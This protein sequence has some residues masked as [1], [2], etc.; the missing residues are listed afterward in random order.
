MSAVIISEIVVTQTSV[1][2]SAAS[3]GVVALRKAM[4]SL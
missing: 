2:S 3:E 1:K 4:L